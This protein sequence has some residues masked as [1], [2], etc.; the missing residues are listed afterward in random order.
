M[1][2]NWGKWI[3]DRGTT[4]GGEKK[5][6]ITGEFGSRAVDGF[7][8]HRRPTRDA[9]TVKKAVRKNNLSRRGVAKRKDARFCST[10]KKNGCFYTY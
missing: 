10:L 8:V 5:R 4:G 1:S 7:V 6:S 2:L 9:G 3:H